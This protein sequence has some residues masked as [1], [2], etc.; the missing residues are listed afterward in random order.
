MKIRTNDAT[1]FTCVS[2]Q[3]LG[4]VLPSVSES[5]E[6]RGD[7]IN[8]TVAGSVDDVPNNAIIVALSIE[9]LKGLL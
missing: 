1:L 3:T 2:V 7:G 5:N 9:I 4:P 6:R 8:I